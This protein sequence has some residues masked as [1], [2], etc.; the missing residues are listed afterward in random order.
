M[1]D[2]G[3]VSGDFDIADESWVTPDAQRVVGEPTGA[4]NLAVVVAPA[5]AGH[6]RAS[7]D[8]V[9]AST[10]SGVPEVNVT[11]IGASTGSEQV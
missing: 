5:Q 7:V 4:N 2:T 9:G 1:K 8:A 10:S 6:L 11:V 3:F